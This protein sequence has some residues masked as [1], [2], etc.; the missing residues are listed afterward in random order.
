MLEGGSSL[1]FF[2][3]RGLV[4]LCVVVKP[5]HGRLYEVV[6]EGKNSARVQLFIPPSSEIVPA[7]RTGIPIPNSSGTADRSFSHKKMTLLALNNI[8]WDTSKFPVTTEMEEAYDAEVATKEKMQKEKRKEMQKE[9][10]K[11]RRE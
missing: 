5:H 1:E 11:R 2:H 6:A 4:S 7:G 8:S 9:K 10:R 3:T